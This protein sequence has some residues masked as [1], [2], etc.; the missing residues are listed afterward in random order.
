MSSSNM[1]SPGSCR[2]S[3]S[4][5]HGARDGGGKHRCWLGHLLPGHYDAGTEPGA[6]MN[7]GTGSSH[8]CSSR[9]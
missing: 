1:K 8:S 6:V 7:S 2:G 5:Q 4:Y 3:G 9:G